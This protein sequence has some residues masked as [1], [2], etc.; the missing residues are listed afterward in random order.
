MSSPGALYLNNIIYRYLYNIIYIITAKSCVRPVQHQ[1]D[2]QTEPRQG[3]E[4]DCS[5]VCLPGLSP[6]GAP[7]P[8]H[9]RRRGTTAWRAKQRL[10]IWGKFK[11][12]PSELLFFS[13]GR[14]GYCGNPLPTRG[15]RGLVVDGV[16]VGGREHNFTHRNQPD[17]VHL[18]GGRKRPG[19]H[20]KRRRRTHSRGKQERRACRRLSIHRIT[21]VSR[22]P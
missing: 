11:I 7:L 22:R 14:A 15:I 18:A 19:G 16:L 13:K 3:G 6:A 9:H 20:L 12:G 5:R 10:S 1:S 17:G 21:R 4:R 2:V 8:G